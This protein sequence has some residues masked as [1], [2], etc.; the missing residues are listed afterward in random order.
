VPYLEDWNIRAQLESFTREPQS[1]AELNY[2]FC[3]IIDRYLQKQGHN[4]ARMNDIMGAFESAKLEFYARV[5]R[6]YEQQKLE[7]NGDVFNSAT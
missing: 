7:D 5:V 4:Y 6:K 3:R 2:V 1:P